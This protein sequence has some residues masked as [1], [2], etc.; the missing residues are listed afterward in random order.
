VHLL[1]LLR[2]FKFGNE[3]SRFLKSQGISWQP[4]HVSAAIEVG[5]LSLKDVKSL[6]CKC[7]LCKVLACNM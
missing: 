4:E 3:P 2:K 5:F 1:V 7:Y 6:S